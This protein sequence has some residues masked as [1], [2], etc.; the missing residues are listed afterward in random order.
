[1]TARII[2]NTRSF[3]QVGVV[4]A[5]KG[6][7]A[8]AMERELY[9]VEGPRLADLELR[10]AKDRVLCIVD[11]DKVSWMH[12]GNIIRAPYDVFAHCQSK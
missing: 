12:L 6:F 1:M 8:R 7:S 3:S 4:T 11:V 2:H 9:T 10:D 5:D